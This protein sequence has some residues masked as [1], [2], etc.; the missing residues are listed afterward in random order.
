MESDSVRTIGDSTLVDMWLDG[1][2]RSISVSRAAVA[3]FQGL[4]PD[5]AAALSDEARRE[6]VRTHLTLVAEAATSRLKDSDA[7]AETVEI[8]AGQAHKQGQGPTG[9]RR[10]GD[11]RKGDRRRAD[12]GAPAGD[13]R[14]S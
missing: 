10:R 9:E 3:A 11:R 13:R 8:D 7:S 5:Q 12:R 6:F 1:K 14:R 4:S 2:V